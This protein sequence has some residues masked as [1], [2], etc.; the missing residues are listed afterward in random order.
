MS[1]QHPIVARGRVYS[2]NCMCYHAE[3]EPVDQIQRCLTL[4]L[5]TEPGKSVSALTL[6][7]QASRVVCVLRCLLCSVHP[8]VLSRNNRCSSSGPS[9]SGTSLVVSHHHW[10][11]RMSH[12][13][14]LLPSALSSHPS[15]FVF[16]DH[17]VQNML[18]PPPHPTP[19]RVRTCRAAPPPPPPHPP[20]SPLQLLST[21]LV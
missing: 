20:Y 9:S 16:H 1:Q 17:Y 3:I 7:R 19:N 14:P 8:R 5:F 10:L 4:W 12:P 15:P 13:P 21:W 6:K 11:H 18:G 2:D